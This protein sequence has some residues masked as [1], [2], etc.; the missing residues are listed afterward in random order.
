MKAA[1]LASLV[2]ACH[3]PGN[4]PGAGVPIRGAT[5]ARTPV[6][7]IPPDAPAMGPARHGRALVMQIRARAHRGRLAFDVTPDDVLHDGDSVELYVQVNAAAYVYVV[8]MA[9]EGRSAVLFPASESEDIEFTPDTMTRIPRDPN[10]WYQLDSDTGTETIYVVASRRPIS[11]SD[12]ELAH[13]IRAIRDLSRPTAP[14]VG[15]ISGVATHDTAQTTPGPARPARDRP[16]PE[17][18]LTLVNRGVR[19]V[20]GNGGRSTID[21]TASD[22]GDLVVGWLAFRH[23]H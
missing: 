3:P 18:M 11:A 22:R 17:R 10:H 20:V 12:A 4:A 1:I 7:P 19:E 14:A 5:T 13:E 6:Q 16:R 21:T 8:Q 2:M 23:E 15:E 9:P